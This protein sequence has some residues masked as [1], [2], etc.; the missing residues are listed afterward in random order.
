MELLEYKNGVMRGD[1]DPSDINLR[2]IADFAEV[3]EQPKELQEER[4]NLEQ[5]LSEV[6]SQKSKAYSEMI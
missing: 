5:F 3:I 4:K 2:P 1:V 6:G